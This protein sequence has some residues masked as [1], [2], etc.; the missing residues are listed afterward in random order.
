MNLEIT[1]V[2]L[3]GKKKKKKPFNFKDFFYNGLHPKY[4]E[5]I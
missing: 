1:L 4:Q 2:Y 5:E 3:N